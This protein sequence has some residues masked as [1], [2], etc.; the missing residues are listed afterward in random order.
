VLGARDRALAR[1]KELYEALLESLI[2]ELPALQRTAAALASS[3]C[4]PA[5][6]NAR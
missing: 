3:T 6:P 5:L 1:E 2:A 4:S